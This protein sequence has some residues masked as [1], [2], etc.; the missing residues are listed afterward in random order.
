[1]KKKHLFWLLLPSYWVLTAI[2]I[3]AVG[4]YAFHS[5]SNLYFQA[6]ENDIHTRATLLSEQVSPLVERMDEQAIDALCK[7]LGNSADTR[8][9]V[10]LPDGKVVGDS[11]ESPGNMEY[12]GGRP[13]TRKAL[14]GDTGMDR[15]YSQTTEQEMMYIAVPLK[16]ENLEILC[17]VRA[18]LPMTAIKG[19]LNRMTVRVVAAAILTGLLAM[20]VC[21]F[22][23]RRITS[24]LLG[25]EHAVRQ[26]SDGNFDHQIPSQ[27]AIEL[28]ELA[29]SFNTMSKQLSHLETVRADFVANV[30]HEL[31]TPITS[32]KGFVETLLSDDW[33]H[34][35]DVLH[36]LEIINQQSGRMN[37]IIDD[38]LTLSRLEQKEDIVLKEPTGLASVLDNAITLC[39]LQAEKKNI[40]ITMTCPE[41][42]TLTI[43][44]PLLEQAFVNL[45]INAIKYSEPNKTVQVLAEK[46]ADQ[47]MIQVKDEGFGIEKKHLHRL[48][49]RFYRV[50]T[51][52]SRNLGGTGLGLSIVNHIVQAHNGEIRVESTL[53]SGSTFRLFLPDAG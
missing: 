26:F 34:E 51:A 24:P 25:M 9:T 45:I 17:A 2:A 20:G 5:M 30:S 15:R 37:A 43:N 35:P 11:D 48:F 13:E 16:N 3:I 8:F 33:S 38:L 22:M 27:Q 31:K 32:I 4:I 50:D 18:A 14:A 40:S 7:K 12:H 41:D 21:I 1:M 39:Q 36:F 6:L 23:V 47:V 29:E 53:G 10:I 49:E 28:D 19:E 42:L 52:R 46:Q 44:A